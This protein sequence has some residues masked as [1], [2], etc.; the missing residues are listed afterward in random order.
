MECSF[1]C[2]VPYI[3]VREMWGGIGV[4]A[5]T[6]IDY[7]L[8]IIH[9]ATTPVVDS[10]K[11]NSHFLHDDGSRHLLSKRVPGPILTVLDVRA[12]C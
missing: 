6:G 3:D 11:S 2:F 8:S 5:V 7:S 4:I 12:Y 1:R 9:P 10:R